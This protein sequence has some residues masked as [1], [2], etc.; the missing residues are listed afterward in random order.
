MKKNIFLPHV[1]LCDIGL[2][3]ILVFFLICLTIVLIIRKKAYGMLK[4][5]IFE[6]INL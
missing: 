5:K 3:Q 4:R 1:I 6:L 2:L